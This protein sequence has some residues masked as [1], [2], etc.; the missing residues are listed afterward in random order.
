[1]NK[2]KQ[3]FGVKKYISRDMKDLKM[4]SQEWMYKNI[5]NMSDD[6]WKLNN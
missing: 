4:I 6:E 3:T 1:M 5:F 2:K